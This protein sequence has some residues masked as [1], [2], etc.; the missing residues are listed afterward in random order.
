MMKVECS[1]C[2]GSS[3]P[4]YVFKWLVGSAK[5]CPSCED[6]NIT[7]FQLA[8]GRVVYR[9]NYCGFQWLYQMQ[10]MRWQGLWEPYDKNF[11]P[12]S[13]KATCEGES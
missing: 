13:M 2:R 12:D 1:M 4:P 9:C 6:R 5:T 8:D 7:C 10:A 3:L 11:E